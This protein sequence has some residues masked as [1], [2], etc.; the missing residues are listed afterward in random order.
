MAETMIKA[1]ADGRVCLLCKGIGFLPEERRGLRSIQDINTM[2]STCQ[3]SASKNNGGP[4][5]ELFKLEKVSTILEKQKKA[6]LK[7][8]GRIQRQQDIIEQKRERLQ[9]GIIGK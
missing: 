6:L 8:A 7:T 5:E 4:L 1:G 2:Q 9:Y 3:H